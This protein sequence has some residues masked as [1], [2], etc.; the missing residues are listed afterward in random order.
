[1]RRSIKPL[2]PVASVGFCGWRPPERLF[3]S[4]T[5]QAHACRPADTVSLRL[6]VRL[7]STWEVRACLDGV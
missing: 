5:K 1:M 6:I 7:A 4:P 2:S 3:D